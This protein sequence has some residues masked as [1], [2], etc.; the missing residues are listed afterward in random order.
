MRRSLQL[1]S[2]LGRRPLCSLPAPP[3]LVA[4]EDMSLA[5]RRRV[6]ALESLNTQYE[7]L[8][9]RTAKAISEVEQ[10]FME[11]S[12]KLFERRQGIVDGSVEPTEEEVAS[13]VYFA[14]L[15]SALPHTTASTSTTGVPRFWPTAL[16]SW[17]SMQ[18]EGLNIT[19]ADWA[20][21]EYLTGLE[22][23]KWEAADSAAAST[24]SD[25]DGGW[26]AGEE[27]EDMA[28][29]GFSIHFHFA[30]NPYLESSEL[31]L[32]VHSHGEVVDFTPPAW[33]D[34]KDPTVRTSVRKIKR[35]GRPTERVASVKPVDS[36]FRVFALPDAEDYG[37]DDGGD[38]P[39]VAELQED[40]VPRIREDLV[41]RGG[42]YFIHALSGLDDG[43]D[44]D[45]Y[46]AEDWEETVVAPKRG[47]KRDGRY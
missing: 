43:T 39:S 22:I 30:P 7:E 2:R 46:D 45:G 20:V 26:D 10:S 36:F 12:L 18:S 24:A 31:A 40:L 27:G 16:Q 28:E 44:G 35:R 32:Y 4:A 5:T 9:Q 1:M 37:E 29:P 3:R 8:E 34:G 42:I 33:L 47:G 17:H 11:E 15:E 41:P 21:L 14:E 38:M 6:A 19:P 23:K 13:S 25:D